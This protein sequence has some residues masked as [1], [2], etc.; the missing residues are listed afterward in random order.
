MISYC[1]RSLI[2]F[3]AWHMLNKCKAKCYGKVTAY[4]SIQYFESSFFLD[5]MDVIQS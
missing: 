2:S 4:E 5:M 3:Y 1:L